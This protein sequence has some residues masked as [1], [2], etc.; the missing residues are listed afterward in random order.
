MGFII[1]RALIA[2]TAETFA[3]DIQPLEK[4]YS[5]MQIVR[6]LKKTKERIS[7]EVCKLVARRYHVRQLLRYQ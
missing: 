6:E 3:E 4:L 7:N 5:K 2:T 1:P